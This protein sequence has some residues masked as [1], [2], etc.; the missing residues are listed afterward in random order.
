MITLV[1]L[2]VEKDDLT[3]RGKRAILSADRV[4]LRTDK[5]L[6][7]ESVKTLGVRY[8]ALDEAVARTRS[9]ATLHKKL[10]K[11]VLDAGRA[12]NV[13]YCVDGNV[14]EDRSAQI[15]MHRYKKSVI[16][17]GISKA[18]RALEKTRMAATSC[19]C[20]SAYDLSEINNLTLPAAIY[21]LDD[22]F[23]A[24]DVKLILSDIIGEESDVFFVCGERCKKIKLYELDRQKKYDYTCAVVVKDIP[25]L[26]KTRFDIADLKE[27]LIRLRRP[28]GCPW[29]KVQTPESIRMNMVEE[30]YELV[31]AIDSG[32]IEKIREETG[33]VL[34]QAVFHAVMQEER[35]GF[36]LTDSLSE[37][38]EKLIHR[39][40]HIFGK[41]K[42]T[43]EAS[44]LSVWEAN[45]Q[46]EKGQDTYSKSVR[47]VPACFPACM[48]AQ[49]VQKRAGKSGFDFANVKDAS[50][51]IYEELKEWEQAYAAGDKAHVH[52]EL[53]DLLFAVVNAGRLSG[54][55]CELAL[56][57][58][59]QKFIRRFT[60]TEELIIADNK[61]ITALSI[62]ELDDYYVKAKSKAKE[63]ENAD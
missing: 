27:I 2:G 57:E 7:A 21:D 52:E 43:D 29:D 22:E 53:G 14:T 44:A 49:K 24:G 15:I 25:L 5:T 30:A 3:E 6:S 56:K 41:D 28:D 48:R 50:A 16:I 35:G 31:D 62:E 54:V 20:V 17:G 11:I 18:Q 26:E 4:I 37:L 59:V 34:L 47:D 33:D 40:T 32:D 19:A 46:K 12:Q 39:H 9:F 36:N 61:D 23:L 38:C 55:D 58:S 1:G 63:R 8:E 45:K 60:L 51:K 10:A 13:V 42:A